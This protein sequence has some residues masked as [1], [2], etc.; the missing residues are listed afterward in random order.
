MSTYD[1]V[2]NRRHKNT[3]DQTLDRFQ[4]MTQNARQQRTIDKKRF[5]KGKKIVFLQQLNQLKHFNAST[6]QH[7]EIATIDGNVV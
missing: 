7:I 3:V 6:I 1:F 2:V 5:Q 4:Q